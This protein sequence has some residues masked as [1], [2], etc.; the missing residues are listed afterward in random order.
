MV[1][2]IMEVVYSGQW[3]YEWKRVSGIVA[4][5]FVEVA[6]FRYIFGKRGEVR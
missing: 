6:E 3:T 2:C 1:C 4:V 5:W